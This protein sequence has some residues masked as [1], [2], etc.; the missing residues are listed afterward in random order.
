MA[1]KSLLESDF[2]QAAVDL[3]CDVASIYAVKEVESK[4]KGYLPSGDPII[5]FERHVFRKRLIAKGISVAGLPE[6]ICNAKM[7]GYFGGQ[8]EHTRLAKAVLIDRD[9]AL[10]S[11]SWGLFQVMGYHWK[12]LGYP[13]LQSFINA[14]FK[15]EDGQLDAFTKY[16]LLDRNLLK[17]LREKN[18]AKFAEGYN[19]PAYTRNQYDVKLKNAYAKWAGVLK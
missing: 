11:C 5:L 13:T 6:D 7:G 10:E 1:D 2:K 12:A 17:A 14:M 4:G 15:N 18:W 9:S 19:G 8:A 16:V 3:A